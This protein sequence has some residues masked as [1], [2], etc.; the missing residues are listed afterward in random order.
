MIALPPLGPR[1]IALLDPGDFTPPY[2]VALARGLIAQGCEL[3][4][5]GQAGNRDAIPAAFRR[6]HFY[7]R[8]VHPLFRQLPRPAARFAKGV[9][10]G[11]DMVRLGRIL[12]AFRA[13]IL[14]CQWSP[15]PV[16][17]R[18]AFRW[19]RRRMPLVLTLHD[20][21][22]YNGAGSALMRAG[23]PGL[24]HEVDAVIVHTTDAARRVVATGLES[25]R[26]HHVPHGLINTAATSGRVSRAGSRLVLLQFGKIKPYKGVDVLLEAL[27][28]VP[29]ALRARLD[30]RIVG[31]PYLDTAPLERIVATNG[32]QDTVRFRFEFVDQ[33]ELDRLLGET[34][35]ILLPYREI[36]ASG[37]AMTAIARGLPVLASAIEGFEELFEGGQGA[38]LVPPGRP[39][40]LADVLRAWAAAP[41][42]L[43]SLAIAMRQRR[44]A[45]PSW[46]EIARR[47]LAV[48]A[49][50]RARWTAGHGPAT[51]RVEM[52]EQQP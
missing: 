29:P 50:A 26:I 52:A 24:V 28:L 37:V 19:F 46:D 17:D 30:V 12:D 15:L 14:H 18:A 27:A 32:L 5:I 33:I 25:G 34:D 4:L 21:K 39:D 44:A 16:V 41:E 49:Q 48:Y 35:A 38:R 7:G 10:H 11:I 20:S 31:K 3:T 9:C 22:P 2:D 1:R 51:A 43:D 23:Y 36:D 45:V 47:T 42:M 6:E 13:E 40:K 8:L